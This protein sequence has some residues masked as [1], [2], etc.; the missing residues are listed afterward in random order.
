MKFRL[1]LEFLSTFDL[2]LDRVRLMVVVVIVCVDFIAAI[3][4]FSLWV[5]LIF[6]FVTII[7][8]VVAVTACWCCCINRRAFI[9]SA[10]CLP[11]LL[12]FH[13]VC[14]HFYPTTSLFSWLWSFLISG[15]FSAFPRSAFQKELRKNTINQQTTKSMFG[16]TLLLKVV[17]IEMSHL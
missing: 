10:L 8:I 6:H 3:I 17:N 7:F 15:D 1:F 14:R 11:F 12:L 9:L 16:S 13:H 5:S 4:L 2:I